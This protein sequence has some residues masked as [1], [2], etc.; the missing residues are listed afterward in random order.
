MHTPKLNLSVA[1][2]VVII[3]NNLLHGNE[4]TMMHALS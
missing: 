1:S 4:N 2:C 3:S